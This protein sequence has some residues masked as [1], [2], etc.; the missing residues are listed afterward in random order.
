MTLH[1]L[2]FGEP[3]HQELELLCARALESGD[4]AAAYRLSDRRCRI[5][6]LPESHSYVLRAE[7]LYHMGERAAAIADLATAIQ[8]APGDL[9]ANRRM[10]AWAKG[11]QQ[12]AAAG[13]LIDREY[14][15]RILKQAIAVLRKSGQRAFARVEVHGRA[16]GGW[17]AWEDSGPIWISIAGETHCVETRLHADPQHPLAGE[18]GSAVG[19]E[20]PRPPGRTS[21]TI[22]VT[23]DRDV[24]VTV[25]TVNDHSRAPVVRPAVAT[26][27]VDAPVTVVVPVYADYRATKSCLHSLLAQLDNSGRHRVIVVDDASPDQR[28]REMLNQLTHRKNL[29][30]LCNA[31]NLGFVGAINRA[32]SEVES[33]D[34]VLL[35]ADTVVPA[36]FI[37]RLAAAA[38]TS[39]DIGTVTPLSN[40]GEFTSFPI[41]NQANPAGDAAEVEK[42]DRIAARANAGDVVDIPNGIGFCLYV[43]RA[44]LDA[45]GELSESY[46]RGYLEDVDFCLRARRRGF[47]NV[48]ATAVYVG[49]AGSRSFGKHKR[50]LVVRNLEVI[51]QRFPAYRAECA[52][53]VLADP[54]KAARQAIEICLP[55]WRPRATL[56]LTGSGTVAEIASERARQLLAGEVPAVLILEIHCRC[57]RIVAKLSDAAGA[58]P[59][60]L[61]FHPLE[62]GIVELLEFLRRSQLARMEFLDLARVP[63]AVVE[64]LLQLNVPHDIYIA[65]AELGLEP[66][67]VQTRPANK[68]LAMPFEQS[69][70]D[71]FF[72]RSV[73]AKADRVLVPDAQ[74]EAVVSS[75]ALHRNTTRLAAAGPKWDHNAKSRDRAA[76]RLGLVPVRGDAQEYQFLRDAIA[77]LAALLPG[78]EIVV[79]G[80]TL[81]DSDLLRAGAFVSGSVD[82]AELA[83][84]FRSYQ[85]DRILLCLLRPLF[86]HPIASAV[87]TSGLP[88]AY[89]DW[90]RGRSRAREGDLPLDQLLSV[91][92]AFER[93]ARWLQGCQSE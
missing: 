39:P 40:N 80:A 5:R 53:F 19:F 70:A 31:K 54:L 92:A 34:V 14:D 49:H 83:H 42:L 6:P 13:T 75:L 85:C 21:Q 59:Q 9:A 35:N 61:E 55:P 10:L 73:I 77:K 38:R 4:V 66:L 69:P 87:M 51:E 45:V 28:I 41:P 76:V 56:L 27:N 60:S 7:A 17:A 62:T 22:S 20:L 58:A 32:L 90:S 15:T 63:R 16:I 8:I 12:I 65:H 88:V 86:G 48:C 64:A 44:C 18:L 2:G 84:L 1:G 72:W 47:R 79:L 33:G 71:G 37:D 89:L 30:V 43:T 46:H 3:H 93:L 67:S 23:K 68:R 25:R 36:G 29:R 74:A 78:L 11:R 50:S 52:D 26:A 57:G 24:L 91:T 82:A 81:E